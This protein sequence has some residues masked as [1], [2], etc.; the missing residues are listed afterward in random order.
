[1]QFMD[2]TLRCGAGSAM[3]AWA[4]LVSASVAGAQSADVGATERA[5]A[6][7]VDVRDIEGSGILHDPLPDLPTP[8][9]R[10]PAIDPSKFTAG[11]PSNPWSGKAGIDNRAP[12]NA[13]LRPEH[14]LPGATPEQ[15]VGVAWATISAPGLMAWDRT[16]IEARVDPYQEG[17]FGV[18]ASRSVP[19]GSMLSLTLQNGLLL[20]QSLPPSGATPGSASASQHNVEG[21]HAV[22]FTLLPADTTLS[23]GVASGDDRWRRSLSAEQK[24]FGGPLNITGA[25]SETAN[26]DL[27]RSLKAGFRRS[28]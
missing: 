9:P 25:V 24:L 8:L 21:S 1:M 18:T 22:R 3:V 7:I 17:R 10:L 12:P 13:E 2:R 4:A 16:S 20:T 28:W 23:I 11:L 14:G 15:G 26:G 19:V 27:S 5:T 6:E